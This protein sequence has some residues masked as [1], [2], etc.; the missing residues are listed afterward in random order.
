[1]EVSGQE[2]EEVSAQAEVTPRKMVFWHFRL[3]SVR[4]DRLQDLILE[5]TIQLNMDMLC[6]GQVLFGLQTPNIP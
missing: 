2:A 6:S 1:V 5:K 4:L 3:R